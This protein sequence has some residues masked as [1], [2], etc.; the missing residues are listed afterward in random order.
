MKLPRARLLPGLQIVEYMKTWS[1]ERV[2]E[3][4][5]DRGWKVSVVWQIRRR[6]D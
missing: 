4:C 1:R 3:Y 6:A 2:R 5:N